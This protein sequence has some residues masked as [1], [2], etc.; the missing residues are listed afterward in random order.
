MSYDALFPVPEPTWTFV[1]T[2]TLQST[3]VTD[4]SDA[5]GRATAGAPTTTEV[6][7]YVGGAD[8]REVSRAASTGVQVDA[9]LRVPHSAPADVAGTVVVGAQT[10]LPPGLAGT[11]EVVGVRPNAADVRVLL[12]R[13]A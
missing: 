13:V 7:G 3:A 12:R 10:G 1:H 6:K 2:V 8:P 9:V 11:Y 4:T 5:R